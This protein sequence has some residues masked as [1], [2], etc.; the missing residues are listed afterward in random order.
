MIKV[1][2][3]TCSILEVV[4]SAS[5]QPVPLARLAEMTEINKA[6][7][8]RIISDLVAEGYLRQVSRQA[9]FTVGDVF[10]SLGMRAAEG[11]SLIKAGMPVVHELAERTGQ[12]VSLVVLNRGRRCV[13]VSRNCDPHSRY[14]PHAPVCRNTLDTAT[15]LVL[16]AYSGPEQMEWARELSEGED[17]PFLQ[18]VEGKMGLKE[19]LEKIR[20]RGGVIQL[21]TGFPSRL[22]IGQ[23][24]WRNG[25]V[26][27]ALG[28]SAP[29]GEADEAYREW[30][31]AAA[32]SL[33]RT[34]STGKEGGR[35]NFDV[36]TPESMEK[37][38]CP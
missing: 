27:A 34:L 35:M 4:V 29:G 13:V 22:V 8:S 30:V 6:T 12:M 19:T 38:S 9:G 37:S 5:P 26:V 15:G 25:E 31:L 2:G 36:V 14:E 20:E 33:S 24:V 18:E 23:P 3:K 10:L 21:T 11:D 7:C 28:F 16:L 1:L 32:E 17:T